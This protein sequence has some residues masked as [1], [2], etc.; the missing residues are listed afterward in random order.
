MPPRNNERADRIRELKAQGLDQTQI[1]EILGCTQ[2]NISALSRT[3]DIVWN[4]GGAARD[5]YG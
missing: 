4:K 1:A 5:Q 2:T 3:H